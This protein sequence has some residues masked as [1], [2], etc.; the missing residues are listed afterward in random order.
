MHTRRGSRV[1]LL[2][3]AN[4]F[5]IETCRSFSSPSSLLIILRKNF[6]FHYH[7]HGGTLFSAF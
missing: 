4:M 2:Y 5:Q 6:G 3:E 1:G 7:V